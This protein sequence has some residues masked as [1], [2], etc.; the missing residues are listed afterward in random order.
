VSEANKAL[1]RRFFDAMRAGD[2]SLPELLSD[3][4]SWWVPPSSPLGG[5]YAG[6]ERVLALM[7][8]GV[9]LY[10]ASVPFAIEIEQMVAE[11][12]WVA[13]QMVMAA[14]TAKG[15]DYRNHYHFAFRVRDG[16]IC[17]VKEYVDTLYAQRMLFERAR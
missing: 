12:D 6:R 1:V 14:R 17:A 13:V 11:G 7:G 15:A 16:R 3:D 5:T 10:D 9:S 8:S 2:A 4:A